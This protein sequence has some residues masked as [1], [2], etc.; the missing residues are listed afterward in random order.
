MLLDPIDA[1]AETTAEDL[2]LAYLEELAAVVS[3]VGVDEA[4]DRTGIP[5]DTL[6]ALVAG[7]QPQLVLD[8]AAAILALTDDWPD[9]DVVMLEI[10]DS[11]MLGMSSAVLDVD[12]LERAL[13][14]GL[15]AKTIQQMIEGRRPLPLATYAAIALTIR[16]ENDYA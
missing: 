8:D 12:A 10:R 15:D 4:A 16:R 2:H 7:E 6:A 9:A 1:P 11:I 5:A 13:D 3:D 14:D